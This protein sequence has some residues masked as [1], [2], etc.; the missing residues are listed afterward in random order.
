MR[1]KTAFCR[2][3]AAVM[4]VLLMISVSAT[5]LTFQYD[6]MVNLVL[7]ASSSKTITVDDDMEIDTNY[8]TSKYGTDYTSTSA[9]LELELDVAAENL[10]QMEEGAVL[11]K[12]ENNALPLSEGSGITIFGNA[13]ANTSGR[14]SAMNGVSTSTFVSAMQDALGTEQVNT[15]LIDNVY[16]ELGAT[17]NTEVVEADVE[18]IRAY[19]DTWQD[20]Y[21]DAAVVVFSRT[22]SE[23]SDIPMYAEDGTTHMLGLAANEAAMMQYLKEQKDA[24]VFKN[25]VVVINTDYIMELDW[26][27]EY[28]VDAALLCGDAGS[29]GFT[30]LANVMIGEVN[31]SGHLVDTYAANSLSA[32]ATTYAIDNTQTWGN[33]DEVNE[34]CDD[35]GEY[36]DYYIIYAEG[37]YVGYKYY[38]TRYE[39]S[40]MG[41]GNAGSTAGSS[42]GNGWS[43]SDEVVYTFGYGLS[44][45]TFEQELNNVTYNAEEDVYEIEVTVT[46][47]GSTAGKDVVEVY[48]QT[49]YGDYEKENLVEKSSVNIVG[50]A[51]TDEL[52]PGESQTLTVEVMRYML[53]SY[54]SNGA[55]G[56]ILSAGDYYFA[57]G[58]DAHDA[59]NN[60]LAAKGYTTADGMT[61]EGN[62]DN[63]YLWNQA[64]LDTESYALS[65]YTGEEVENQFEYAD[66]NYYGIDFTYLSRND[67]EGTYPSEALVVNATE[68]MMED[69][70]GDWYETPEDAP[71]VSDFTQGA[72]NGLTFIDMLSVDY[73]DDETWDKFLDQLTVE[74]MAALISDTNGS[75]GIDRIGMPSQSRTNDNISASSL[76][77]TGE[78]TLTWVSAVVTARTWNTDRYESRGT[79]MSLECAFCGISEN[80]YGGGNIH[81]TPF[82][83][84]TNQYYSEDG[85]FSYIVGYYEAAAMQANGV[86]CCV[87]HFALNDQETHRESVATFANEQSIREEYLRA[88]EGALADGNAASVMTA[89]NRIGVK[90]AGNN[91]NLITNV[92][93][94]EWGFEG[95]ATPDGYSANVFKTHYLETIA[96]GIDYNC[97]DPSYTETAVIE[98]IDNGDGYMLECLRRSAKNNVYA[99][100]RTV[101]ANGLSTNSIVVTVVPWWKT[102][103]LAADAVFALGF[104]AFA[105]LTAV[106]LRPEKGSGRRK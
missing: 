42:T 56:Y 63:T 9:A 31:P 87:K 2:G 93:R 15:A 77:A 13:S 43:Y 16:S 94:E 3:M 96:A 92:L 50:F 37:I 18:A 23:G 53:A 24:G 51:K 22:G 49:P 99:S 66:L 69:L 17:S 48:A 89:F 79:Y 36:V 52:M 91:Y 70:D 35:G 33:V 46:N 86:Q 97:L 27:E 7:G 26:L 14:S 34:T 62:A 85:N 20:A 44:Y 4:A 74:E 106:W 90:Y 6:T 98:A 29:V 57:I 103:L 47:T 72:D 75:V 10:R 60:I 28:E 1:K 88:F 73:D 84:R 81:R 58:D 104:V 100:V 25:I 21:N 8:Y 45:T 68:E 65:V 5:T 32:P 55:E 80:W 59:L 54:D 11:L 12:N 41:T 67:W 76:L 105:V 95:H 101:L 61:A 71:D 64:E 82:G 19:E 83:G 39:D 40:V 78:S 30:G 102:A 38:E